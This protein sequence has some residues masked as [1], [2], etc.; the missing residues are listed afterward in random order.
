MSLSLNKIS[1]I[2][3]AS[4]IAGQILKL[5]VIDIRGPAILDITL[6]FLG[7][8]GLLKTLPKKVNFKNL[9]LFFYAFIL[10]IFVCV[11]SLI[12]NPLDLGLPLLLVSGFYIL[13]LFFFSLLLFF[14]LRKILIFNINEIFIYAGVILS[15]LGILQ[16]IFIPDLRFL[17]TSGWDPHYFRAVS[18]FLDPNFLGGFL[19][20]SLLSTFLYEFKNQK[21]RIFFLSLL[22]ICLTLTF[23]RSSYLFFFVSFFSLGL[24]A[25]SKRLFSFS[26]LLTLTLFLNFYIYQLTVAVPRNIDREDSAMNRF[27]TWNQGLE[28]FLKHPVFGVGF[29]NYK[30]ALEKYKLT[31]NAQ[32]NQR[33]SASNDASLLFV[34]STTGLIGFVVFLLFIISSLLYGLRSRG[35]SSGQIVFSGILGLL[36]NSIFINSVFYPLIFIWLILYLGALK[37]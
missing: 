2:L 30:Y 16:F 35:V 8:L 17:Q 1:T 31:N 36:V 10:F 21:L 19:V 23:S 28:L 4:L 22:Y 15:I 33:G 3:T 24:L 26:I 37:E 20:L 9:P 27:D 25:R 6:I 5:P 12:L 18:T 29:N 14:V 11:I 34:L 32:I 7:L 13:R